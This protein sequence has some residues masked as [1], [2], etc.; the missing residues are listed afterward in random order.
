MES[1]VIYYIIKSQAWTF[2]ASLTVSRKAYAVH[3]KSIYPYLGRVL[4]VCSSVSQ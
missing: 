2:Q 4:L 3:L 1:V